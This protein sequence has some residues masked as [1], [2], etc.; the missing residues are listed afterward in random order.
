MNLDMWPQF[1]LRT[2][3]QW[4]VT[5]L[6]GM[7]RAGFLRFSTVLAVQKRTMRT[8]MWPRGKDNL[9]VQQK[10]Q[11]KFTPWHQKRPEVD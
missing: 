1:A 3:N 5:F 10:L 2:R 8:P 7:V 6:W 4:N 9:R 11:G